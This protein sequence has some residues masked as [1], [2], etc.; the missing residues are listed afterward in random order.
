MPKKVKVVDIV[1]NE[2]SNTEVMPS[3]NI[4]V[5]HT[6]EVTNDNNPPSGGKL[7][8]G[9]FGHRT[10]Q[11]GAQTVNDIEEVV[12]P[13]PKS[14]AKPR[15]KKTPVKLEQIKED[16]TINEPIQE[17]TQEP[18]KEPITDSKIQNVVKLVKCNKCNR[19]MNEKTLRYTHEANCKGDKIDIPVKR[20]PKV[21]IDNQSIKRIDN[22]IPEEVKQEFMRTIERAKLKLQRREENLNKL[23]LQI[24]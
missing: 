3:E 6:Q 15:A 8:T 16:E 20:R 4:E 9:P 22:D 17:P 23:R 7:N 18:I 1:S 11:G 5:N 19:T 12:K 21:V 24:A 10:P 2:N 13:K 14:R